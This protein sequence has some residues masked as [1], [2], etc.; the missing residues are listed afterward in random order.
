MDK[1]DGSRARRTFAFITNIVR[2]TGE[3]PCEVAAI[4]NPQIPVETYVAQVE[5]QEAAN[6]KRPLMERVKGRVTDLRKRWFG[7]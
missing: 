2:Y 4:E 1:K 5:Q 7:W 3:K 6:P